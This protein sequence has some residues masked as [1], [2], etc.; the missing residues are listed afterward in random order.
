M[1]N[2]NL[3]EGHRIKTSEYITKQEFDQIN[4]LMELCCEQ[5][6]INLKLELD[7]KLHQATLADQKEAEVSGVRNEFLYYV[8]GELVS[9]LG[10]S[11]FDG[12]TGEI[13]GMTHP[14]FRRQGFYTLLLELAHKECMLRPFKKLLILTDGNSAAGMQYIKSVG[15]AFAHS[16]YRMKRLTAS[17]ARPS[18][19]T[20]LTLRTAC[21]ED[22]L[23]IARMNTKFFDDSEV[24]E[25]TGEPLIKALE[26]QPENYKTYMVELKGESIGKINVEY[27]GDY[28][29]ICGFG[30]Q[31]EH[32]GKGYGRAA[33]DAAL[34]IIEER[35][36]GT[37]ELDVVCTN[38][39][40][41]TLYQSCGFEEQSVMNYYSV[42]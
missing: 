27:Q 22:E 25:Q 11:C 29:F 10:I 23:E 16:E 4:R 42:T 32:R 36:I 35:K 9:Y 1:T 2:I 14:A 8:G 30:I 7:Y 40:A 21:R 3:P 34:A 39:R 15:F 18:T 5:D 13:T 20:V 31:P 19:S 41:L 17:S 28:A 37:T 24:D 33:L 6:K 38:A 26:E 12:I